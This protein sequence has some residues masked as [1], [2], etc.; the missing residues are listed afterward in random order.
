MGVCCRTN[1]SWLKPCSW[2]SSQGKGSRIESLVSS[3]GGVVIR[4][5]FGTLDPQYPASP[6]KLV[7]CHLHVRLGK[8]WLLV[9]I[10]S[11]EREIVL[12]QSNHVLSCEP[13][14]RIGSFSLEALRLYKLIAVTDKLN[15]FPNCPL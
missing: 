13:F 7:N 3:Y 14:L 10:L 5:K 12:L 9:F 2:F 11:G 1:F 8:F 15:L 4:K 6:S